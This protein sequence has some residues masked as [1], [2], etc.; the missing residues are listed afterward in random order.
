[1]SL[2]R[3]MRVVVPLTIVILAGSVLGWN[4]GLWPGLAHALAG[5]GIGAREEAPQATAKPADPG[6][7]R[8]ED[9]A[10]IRAAD[11]AFV[12]GYNKA[13]TKGLTAFFTEDAEVVEDSGET[14]LGRAQIEKSLAATF[15]AAKGAR[16]A[17]EVGSLRFVTPDVA[18]EEG[19]SIVTSPAGA[20]VSRLYTVLFVKRGGRW[21]ISSEREEPDP[22]VRPHERLKEL[23]W[24]LGD[25]LDE[26]SDSLVRVHCRWAEDGNFLIRSFTVHHRGKPVMTVTQRI[27]WD[28]LAR[29]L[30]SWEFDSE[31]GYG[32]GRWSRDSDRWIVKHTGVRPEGTTASSTNIMTRERPDLVRWSS[33][34]RVVGDEATTDAQSYVLVRVLPAPRERPPGQVAPSTT[35]NTRSPR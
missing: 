23:E 29:Q 32:E 24:M 34:D 18:R 1:M 12:A 22:L 16:L 20:P 2:R 31:G 5:A 4:G 27:G 35:P 13:D 17:L 14:Y 19:R 6:P 21:L 28:P 25:W 9:E 7:G 3:V 8:P 26:G 30:R 33:T 10:A 15:A 11:D